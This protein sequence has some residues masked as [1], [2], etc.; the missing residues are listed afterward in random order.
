MVAGIGVGVVMTEGDDVDG[1]GGVD[2]DGWDGA[3]ASE[4]HMQ[5]SSDVAFAI[6][7]AKPFAGEG[8]FM[9]KLYMLWCLGTFKSI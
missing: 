6:K 4:I 5:D 2:D 7:Q 3:T 9:S 8:V 1:T